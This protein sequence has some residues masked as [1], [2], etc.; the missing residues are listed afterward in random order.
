MQSLHGVSQETTKLLTEKLAL[1]REL[2][3]LRPEVEHLRSQA[4]SDQSL[5]AEKLSL[6]RQLSALQVEL[7]T[8]K[9]ATQRSL[10]KDGGAKAHEARLE[11]QLDSLKAELAK[12]RRERQKVERETQKACG[13]FESKQAIL[14]S[15]LDAFRNKLRTTKDQLKEAQAEI[16]RGRNAR[17]TE[18]TRPEGKPAASKK[19][20]LA[21]ADE[22][23][24]VGTPGL[25]AAFKKARRGSTLL[26]DKS[27]FSITPFLNRT[28]SLA[29]ESPRA[30]S[31]TDQDP[32]QELSRPPSPQATEQELGSPMERPARKHT[33]KPPSK[34]PAAALTLTKS[35][36]TNGRPAP[37]R[38]AQAAS[39]L[40][41]VQEEEDRDEDVA[42]TNDPGHQPL[43][44]DAGMP[45]E[46]P[47]SSITNPS[48]EPA[49]VKK[50]RKMLGG[51]LGRTL[52]DDEDDARPKKTSGRVNALR[53]FAPPGNGKLDVPHFG[54]VTAE[55]FGE[56]SPLKKDRRARGG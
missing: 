46:R 17:M 16:E 4:A 38:K 36:K 18:T 20:S 32:P 55:G 7:E 19:R 42:S 11:A 30:A 14:E 13:E 54:A 37:N 41:K 3:N 48:A 25:P 35:S 1:S 24:A 45:A 27:T 49:L 52:F 50:K 39:S 12:E 31:P 10:S 28:A 29:P 21:Q 44:A 22:D 26:G 23:T 6:V 53:G 43:E 56:F 5:L 2:A 34:K 33:K 9:R 51:G 47:T 8:E 40:E 15:R